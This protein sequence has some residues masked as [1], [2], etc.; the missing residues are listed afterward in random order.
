MNKIFTWAPKVIRIMAIASVWISTESRVEYH[1][2]CGCIAESVHARYN[3]H[4]IYKHHMW[5][6]VVCWASTLKGP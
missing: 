3:Y 4:K 2:R 1:M 5:P 6:I